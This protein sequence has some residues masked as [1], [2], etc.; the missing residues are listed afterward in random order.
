MVSADSTGVFEILSVGILGGRLGSMWNRGN[1]T[2]QRITTRYR[3]DQWFV[4]SL[5]SFHILSRLFFQFTITNVWIS[6]SSAMD[7]A[8]DAVSGSQNGETAAK[9]HGP[10]TSKHALLTPR[11]KTHTM[12]IPAR[13]LSKSGTWRILSEIYPAKT[14]RSPLGSFSRRV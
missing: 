12:D 8:R 6:P 14:F 11:N 9:S 4:A 5:V 1:T 13:S 2:L 3:S 10:P 7:C